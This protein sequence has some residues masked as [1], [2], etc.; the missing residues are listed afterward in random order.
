[1]ISYNSLTTSKRNL[2]FYWIIPTLVIVLP[3]IIFVIYRAANISFTHDECLSYGISTG[4]D[5]FTKTPNNHLL[6]TLLMKFFGTIT[7]SSEISLRMPNVLAFILYCIA[8][9]GI[10]RNIKKP[11]LSI[12]F[13]AILVLNTLMLEFFGLARGYGL[14]MGLSMAGYYCLFMLDNQSLP[15]KKYLVYFVLTLIFS[16][17]AVYSNLSAVN[18]HVAILAVLI[19]GLIP[20]IKTTLPKTKTKVILIFGGIL[21]A[22]I[23]ALLPAISRLIMLRDKN[24]LACFGGSEGL[25]KTTITSLIKTFFYFYPFTTEIF[26][27][28]LIIVIGVFALSGIWVVIKLFRKQFDNFSRTFFI[29]LLLLLAPV[30]QNYFF[31]IPYP[32]DRTALLYYPLFS[33]LL[34]FLFSNTIF[35]TRNKLI[36]ALV[37]VTLIGTASF[38]TFNSFKKFNLKY[39]CYLW[40]YDAYDKQILEIIDK[41]RLADGNQDSV[42][43]SCSWFYEPAINYYRIR[44]NYTWLIPADRQGPGKEGDYYICAVQELPLIKCDSV[45][46]LKAFDD[47]GTYLLKRY[48]AK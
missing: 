44:R 19:A 20:Y 8:G 12:F 13:M 42:R 26:S 35:L 7:G 38:I 21:L 14:S 34:I 25:I 15:V 4:V 23:L 31:N 47:A 28:V 16:M 6:N 2:L 43:I 27:K 48:K 32:T 18:L 36:K 3:A 39:G 37:V 46:V 29:L 33:L 9:L 45:I 41:D 40:Q 5:T 11:V 30:L 17:L 22:D 10:I 24:E 1:M